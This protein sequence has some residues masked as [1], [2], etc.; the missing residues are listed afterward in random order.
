MSKKVR[1][2]QDFQGRETREVF[3]KQGQEVELPD[4]IAESLLADRRVELV[5]FPEPK[6]VKEFLTPVEFENVTDVRKEVEVEN[7]VKP[8]Y[9]DSEPQFENVAEP[10][11]PTKKQRGK[12]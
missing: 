9:H 1:F 6:T 3:Y 4:H 10:P 12:K 11:K 2:L 7:A 5:D 8:V